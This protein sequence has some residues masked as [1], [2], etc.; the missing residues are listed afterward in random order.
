MLWRAMYAIALALAWPFVVL[1]VRFAAR[2]RAE[3]ARVAERF[4]VVP[5]A[6][7]SGVAWVHAVSAGEV[8]ACAPL[9]REL[10]RRRPDIGILVTT[11]TVT[12]SARARALLGEE[13]YHCYA[14]YDFGDAVERFVARVA[15]RLVVLIETELW[16]NTIRVCRARGVDVMLV[17]ARLSARS[18]RGYAAIGALSRAML[19]DLAWIACQSAAHRDRFVA[20]GA[21]AESVDV[22]G[23]VKFDGAVP[24]DAARIA[25]EL[26][27]RLALAA[28][29]VWIAA[30]THAGEDEIA[31]DAH[32][33]MLKRRPDLK[34]VLV[35]RHPERFAAVAALAR[36]R[37]FTV[38]LRSEANPRRDASVVVGDSM[39]ELFAYYSTATVA[40]VGGS[41]VRAGGHNPIEPARVGVPVL[42]GP[43][44]FNFADVYA[45][46]EDAHALERVASA[47]ELAARVERA[48]NDDAWRHAR[49]D[50]ARAVIEVNTGAT[51]RIADR[52]VAALDARG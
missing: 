32:A 28:G 26:R 31:L 12:G 45:A 42:V 3:R 48:L 5:D 36:A 16:P 14:P 43:H 21:P 24:A 4:G 2:G 9:V 10:A 25:S 34:L 37:G 40:F 8:I 7:P 17:N 41:L 13:V 51:A 33:S 44:T 6:I 30:S 20:L 11:T 52:L 18:A 22:V 23:N 19:G 35:P 50:A 29:R 39:G 15:P 49:V 46:F 47:G 27:D 38:A 1:R